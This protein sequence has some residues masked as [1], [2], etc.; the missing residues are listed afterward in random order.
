MFICIY[1]WS[2]V[3]QDHRTVKMYPNVLHIFD[4]MD[5]SF[6]NTGVNSFNAG[7][8]FLISFLSLGEKLPFV[9]ILI[10]VINLFL[11]IRLCTSF[12]FYCIFMHVN[13][14]GILELYYI[15]IFV[16]ILRFCYGWPLGYFIVCTL[17][18][19]NLYRVRINNIV[20]LV[21]CLRVSRWACTVQQDDVM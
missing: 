20:V 2:C 13:Y 11:Y 9:L 6:L 3:S 10:R 5:K 8:Y 19:L 18:Y 17:I 4:N 21:A 15:V 14:F 16:T 1:V 12:Y 7:S